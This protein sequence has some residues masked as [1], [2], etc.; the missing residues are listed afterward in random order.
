MSMLRHRL[1]NERWEF[2]RYHPL[3]YS[4]KVCIS[5]SD[6]FDRRLKNDSK[7]VTS[8]VARVNVP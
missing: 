8:V 2:A 3:S 4:V 5:F 7:S 1:S 6:S